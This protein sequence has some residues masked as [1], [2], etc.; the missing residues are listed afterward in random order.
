MLTQ[1]PKF[2]YMKP[3]EW[4]S[5]FIIWEAKI[6]KPN[7]LVVSELNSKLKILIPRPV[8]FKP[9]SSSI[10][11]YYLEGLDWSRWGCLN[12]GKGCWHISLYL[13]VLFLRMEGCTLTKRCKWP[14]P[15]TLWSCLRHSKTSLWFIS[16]KDLIPRPSGAKQKP[17]FSFVWLSLA[18]EVIWQRGMNMFGQNTG[19]ALTLRGWENGSGWVASLLRGMSFMS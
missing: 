4:T 10:V 14:L 7:K 19:K 2:C 9:L 17:R 12:K 1:Y 5:H 8:F 3:L 13:F 11:S 18:W 16:R 15:P 6:W